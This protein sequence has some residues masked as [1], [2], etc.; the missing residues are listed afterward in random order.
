MISRNSDL[1][2]I[3]TFETSVKLGMKLVMLSLVSMFCVLTKVAA[4]SSSVPTID[5]ALVEFDF[6]EGKTVYGSDEVTYYMRNYEEKPSKLIVFIQGTDPNPLFFFNLTDD[7]VSFQKTFP[8]DRKSLDSTYAYA[9]VAKPGLSGIFDKDSFNVPDEYRNKNYKKY[10]V[11]KVNAAIDHILQK[12]LEDP[13]KIIVY[14]HSE[15]AQVASALALENSR[16]THLGF[17]SGNV[18]NNF[19]EFALFERIAALK[20]QQSDSAAHE[21]IMQLMGW[22]ESIVDNPLSTEAD[23]WGY[24][25]RRWSSYEEAPINELLKIDIPIYALFATKDESTPI[26]TAYLL[27]VQFLQHRK[28]NLSFNV[29][30]NCDHSYR[31]ELDGEMVSRWSEQFADFIKW[32]EN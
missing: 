19:Y 32:T 14:G 1:N 11:G 27:P 13:E 30:M 31:E 28:D 22:Y 7:G 8:D 21:N 10:R 2:R 20:G 15:G 23:E 9:V 24:T 18:L 16:I 29:C 4:Q 5:D 6:I 3:E 26:E 12:H 25:N 17:W